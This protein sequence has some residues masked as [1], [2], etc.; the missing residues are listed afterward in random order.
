MLESSIL[1]NIGSW[2]RAPSPDVGEFLDEYF[3]KKRVLVAMSGGVDSSVTAALLQKEGCDV[4]GVTMKLTAGVCCD[5]GSA[6][7]V[8]T[9]LGIPHRMLDAQ[10]DF[11]Q[12]V[13]S[14][15]YFRIPPWPHAE[16]LHQMQ[17][18]RQVPSPPGL[19][20]RERL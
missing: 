1:R 4:E 19:R 14:E 15:F 17:R 16:P 10:T 6:Q 9:H 7:A 20:A 13:Y 18:P 11:S 8:C 2:L 5:I 12:V 3:M